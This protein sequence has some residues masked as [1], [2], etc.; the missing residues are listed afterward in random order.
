MTYRVT[1][2][3]ENGEPEV[4]FDDLTQRQAQKL[5]SFAAGRRPRTVEWPLPTQVM[6]GR[7]VQV[8]NAVFVIQRVA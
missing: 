8:G 4:E 2:F 1:R 5:V 3:N 7:T 6:R